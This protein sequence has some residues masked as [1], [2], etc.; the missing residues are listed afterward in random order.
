MTAYRPD[1]AKTPDKIRI[2]GSV[3]S[4]KS[5]LARALSDQLGIPY[6]ELDNMVWRR[7][8]HGDVK[9][10]FEERDRILNGILEQDRWIIE[11]VHYQ[12]VLRSFADA[13]LIVY[14]DTPIWVRNYR[15]LK[16]FTVQKLGLAQGNY[17]QTFS[18]LRKMYQWNYRHA[19][20]EKPE[21]MQIVEPYRGKLRMIRNSSVRQALMLP[22]KAR[23]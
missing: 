17:K 2:I 13:D 19:K 15:I 16:R 12:W 6:Y 3:G 21:I 14:V 5:T 9:N 18:M 1:S 7:T 23:P 8:D 22:E 10:S 4:G 11:G 20:K